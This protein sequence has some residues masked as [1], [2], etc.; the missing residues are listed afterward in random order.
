MTRRQNGT[1]TAI[2]TERLSE[3]ASGILLPR[4]GIQKGDLINNETARRIIEAVKSVDE[5]FRA[6]FHPDG[7]GGVEL[8]IVGP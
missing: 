2:R 8:V 5:H 1:L 7:R 4:L 3:T 6:L